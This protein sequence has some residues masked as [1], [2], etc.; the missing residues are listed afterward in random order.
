MYIF[1]DK[2]SIKEIC[3]TL[4]QKQWTKIQHGHPKIG[5][6]WEKRSDTSGISQHYYIRHYNVKKAIDSFQNTIKHIKSCK[7]TVLF[8][9][10]NENEHIKTIKHY[11]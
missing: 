8:I 6:F 4:Q 9:I 10:C 1:E 7:D 3:N 5:K 2:E 11:R